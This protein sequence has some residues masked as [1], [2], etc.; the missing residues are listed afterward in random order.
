MK[1]KAI[2][3]DT[4]QKDGK[5]DNIK[6]YCHSNGIEIIRQQLY[7]G[8]YT[9]IKDQSI[10]IDTKKD[11]SE[12]C[13]DLGNDKG[14][15]M[16][17]VARA[18]KHG[19]KLIVLTEHSSNIKSIPD[20]ASWKNPILSPSHPKHNPNALDGR[21]LMK[22]IYDVHIQYGTEFLFCEKAETGQKII[23]LLQVSV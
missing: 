18:K 12:L 23:D 3:E 5:H 10:C 19:I 21:K 17:E 9:L 11:L 22:R 16:R 7:V 20:V 2:F 6:A 13:M 4:R 1:I 14:R 15:F 8:D